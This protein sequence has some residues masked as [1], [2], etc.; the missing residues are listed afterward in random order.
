MEGKKEELNLWVETL[1]LLNRFKSEYIGRGGKGSLCLIKLKSSSL[2][3]DGLQVGLHRLELSSHGVDLLLHGVSL[4]DDLLPSSRSLL[5]LL[6]LLGSNGLNDFLGLLMEGLHEA[7]S[8]VGLA[9][10]AA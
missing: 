7:D 10:V 6:L 5:V 1:A 9:S 8:I 4:L 3:Q 2:L